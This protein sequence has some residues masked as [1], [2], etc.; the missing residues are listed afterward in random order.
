MAADLAEVPRRHLAHLLLRL[1]RTAG[2]PRAGRAFEDYQ[3]RQL[4]VSARHAAYSANLVLLAVAVQGSLRASDMF[5]TMKYD[6]ASWQSQALLWYSQL[7]TCFYSMVDTL[8]VERIWDGDRRD[9]RI[10]LD[11]GR[12]EPAPIDPLWTYELS[13]RDVPIMWNYHIGGLNARRRVNFLARGFSDV[14]LHAIEP[15]I[16]HLGPSMFGFHGLILPGQEDL[17]LSGARTLIDAW[18]LSA[19]EDRLANRDEVYLRCA[20]VCVREDGAS[21]EEDDSES[22][23]HTAL[24]LSALSADRRASAETA[25]AVMNRIIPWKMIGPLTSRIAECIMSFL[26]REDPSGTGHQ[27]LVE[28]LGLLSPELVEPGV[29]RVLRWRIRDLGLTPPS[30]EWIEADAQTP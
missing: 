23:K 2:L 6:I 15:I 26:L 25:S 18:L 29:L 12:A 8:A 24:L 13:P 1:G 20:V 21:S 11:D 28:L 22:H 27:Q 7:G 30:P 16:E 14:M 3:P 9:L 17:A 10:T 19:N 4:T 5:P